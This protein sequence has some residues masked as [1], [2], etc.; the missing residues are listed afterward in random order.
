MRYGRGASVSLRDL[1]KKFEG[2]A[3][4]GRG[5]AVS[6]SCGDGSLSLFTHI[7]EDGEAKADAGV[8]AA[9]MCTF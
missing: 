4:R 2:T 5:A 1:G 7:W 3:C 8:L 6:A 9:Y